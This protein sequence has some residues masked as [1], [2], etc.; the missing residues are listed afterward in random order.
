MGMFLHRVLRRTE[1]RRRIVRGPKKAGSATW[2]LERCLG[3][4][5]TGPTRGQGD[6]RDPR[7]QIR[8]SREGDQGDLGD[9]NLQLWVGVGKG[10]KTGKVLHGLELR[11]FRLCD[12]SRR[13]SLATATKLPV[14]FFAHLFGAGC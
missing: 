5:W 6:L 4:S 1:G 10:E 3:V 8:H 14:H 7:R 12:L 11:D 9:F 13:A 2:R